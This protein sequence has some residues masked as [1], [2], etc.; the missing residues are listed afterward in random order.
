MIL[1]VLTVVALLL[2]GLAA[3]CAIVAMGFWILDKCQPPGEE[4]RSA[5]RPVQRSNC[6]HCTRIHAGP[7]DCENWC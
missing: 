5:T 3:L 2:L 1:Y 6:S 4:D 7:E